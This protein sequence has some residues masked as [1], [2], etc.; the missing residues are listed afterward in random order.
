MGIFDLHN[1]HLITL[2][3]GVRRIGESNQFPHRAVGVNSDFAFGVVVKRNLDSA[4]AASQ[5]MMMGQTIGEDLFSGDEQ[6]KND[7]AAAQ[8]SYQY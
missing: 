4:N 7:D 8:H 3:E 6:H 1:Q 5:G 2:L